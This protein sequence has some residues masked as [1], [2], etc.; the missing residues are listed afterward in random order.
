MRVTVSPLYKPLA[1]LFNKLLAT[2]SVPRQWKNASIRYQCPKS[3]LPL[4]VQILGLCLSHQFFAELWWALLPESSCILE[5]ATQPYLWHLSI[6]TLSVPH[7][8]PLLRLLPYYRQSPISWQLNHLLFGWKTGD[9]RILDSLY[10]AIWR[11]SLRRKWT[12]SDEIRSTLSTLL[13]AGCSRF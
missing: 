12:D 4:T 13:G 2:S 7:R 10:G 1:Y 11:C 3:H 5:S 9:R 8:P 6:N